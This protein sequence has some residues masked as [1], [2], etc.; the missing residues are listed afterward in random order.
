NDVHLDFPYKTL[1]TLNTDL[2]PGLD[3]VDQW[4]VD[5]DKKQD[6]RHDKV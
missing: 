3:D 4:F 1:D 6:W 5:D 2:T